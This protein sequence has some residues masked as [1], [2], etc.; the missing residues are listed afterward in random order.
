M[1][2]PDFVDKVILVTRTPTV[3][4]LGENN[5]NETNTPTSTFNSSARTPMASYSKSPGISPPN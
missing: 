3:N 4:F 5:F 1:S 2:D